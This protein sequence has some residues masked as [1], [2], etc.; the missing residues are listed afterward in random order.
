MIQLTKFI[1]LLLENMYTSF[2]RQSICHLWSWFSIKM[3]DVFVGIFI[4]EW[5]QDSIILKLR[6]INMWKQHL[7]CVFDELQKSRF[8]S[9]ESYTGA[10]LKCFFFVLFF[11]ILIGFLI[12]ILGFKS[13]LFVPFCETRQNQSGKLQIFDELLESNSSW[14]RCRYSLMV[15]ALACRFVVSQFDLQPR[16]YVHFR[17]NILRGKVWT[18][19]SS[20]L[21]V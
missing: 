9:M 16:Y 11:T 4:D 18:P 14:R 8:G 1:F 12:L 5:L 17:T 2:T 15:K 13:I 19:L 21:W 3:S 20:Q 6:W 7:F 10:F